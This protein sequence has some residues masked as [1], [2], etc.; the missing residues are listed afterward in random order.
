MTTENKTDSGQKKF[1]RRERFWLA[2]TAV[3]LAGLLLMAAW[4]QPSPKGYGTHRRLGLPPCTFLTLVGRPCP[5]CGMTTAWAYLMKGQ[6]L[7]ALR[8]NAGGALLCLLAVAA[9]PWLLGS[10]IRG[11]WFFG[12]LRDA[13]IAWI[14]AVVFAV[15]SIQWLCRL[16]T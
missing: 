11:A 14:A 5:S 16:L 6:W 15:M 4:L 13:T 10:A 12:P 8:A 7:E 2:A 1:S 9:V 3:G